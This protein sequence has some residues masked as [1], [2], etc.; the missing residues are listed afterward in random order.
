M[1]CRRLRRAFLVDSGA[2]VSVFP[3]TSAQKKVASSSHLSAA[4]GS[5][6]ATYGRRDIFLS[7][8]GLKV[9]HSFLL[10][11]VR[12]PILGSDFFRATGLIIDIPRRRLVLSDPCA[13]T[14]VRA[15]PARLLGGVCGLR[16]APLES[17]SV[18][19]VLERFP[20]VL[21]STASFDSTKPAKHGISHT[22][23]TSGPPVYARARQLF[24][25]KLDVAK[26]EFQKMVDMKIIRPSN[27]P[28]ASPLHV[29]P[30]ADGGWR[31][32]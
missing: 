19:Q 14:V 8:P 30:K 10:A 11:N 24:G 21:L 6:I 20:S 4:N 29:V 28:W 17:T 15:R 23:P 16:S 22:I 2:D 7:F 13:A 26:S 25:E 18:D 27:S 9:T 5:S 31:L 32:S 1:F 12:R 3:A